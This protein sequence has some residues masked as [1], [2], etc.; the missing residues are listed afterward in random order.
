MKW[1]LWVLTVAIALVVGLVIR[2]TFFNPDSESSSQGSNRCD[3]AQTAYNHA[4]SA[5][6]IDIKAVSRVVINDPQCWSPD[7]VALGQQCLANAKSSQNARATAPC[8]TLL[9]VG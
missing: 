8:Q 4:E 9:A 7:L 1:G 5:R 2:G 6:P 3:Q